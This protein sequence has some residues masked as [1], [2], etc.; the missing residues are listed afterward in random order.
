MSTQADTTAPARHETGTADRATAGGGSGSS[1]PILW[2]ARLGLIPYSD[3]FEL[4]QRLQARRRAEAIPD[5]MLLLEHPPVY[6]RGRRSSEQELTLGEA[7][8]R[9][10]G[11]EVV[12]TDRGGRV[13]YHGPGQLVGYPIMRVTDVISHLRTMERAII[14]ALAEEGV[15]AR[16]RCEE[17]PDWTGVWVAERK[18]A[19]LGVH[20]SRGVSTHGFAVNIINDLDPFTW[21]VP[22][23]L[24]GVRMTSIAAE[25]GMP[26]RVGDGSRS[27]GAHP[28]AEPDLNRFADRVI[29]HFCEI[30]GHTAVEVSAAQL[31]AVAPTASAAPPAVAA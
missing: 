30:H 21:I 3:A 24:A 31:E 6:T 12:A 14:S 8:Y 15:L 11:I 5:T 27:D 4:Q 22:C 2:V 13:T 26:G 29:A 17:G 19:S 9:E 28:A 18:I 25:L 16:S 10:R 1:E 23:G 7:F 20:V